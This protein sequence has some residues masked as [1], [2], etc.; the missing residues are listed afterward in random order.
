MTPEDL[1]RSK[2]ARLA[3]ADDREAMEFAA[4]QLELTRQHHDGVLTL[5]DLKAAA[6]TR[7]DVDRLLRRNSL[8]QVHRTVYVDH[9]G[10][11]TRTQRIWAAVF[12]LAPAVICGRTL[13]AP[14]SLTELDP[15]DIA[16]DWT[17]RVASPDGV[18]VHRVRHLDSVAQ[19]KAEPP[20]MRR[21]DAVL[22]LVDAAADDLE[23]VRLLTDAARDLNVGVERLREAERRRSRLRRRLFVVALLDDMARGAQSVL[24]YGYLTRVERAHGLPT[25][26]RQVLRRTPGGK[27]YRDVEYEVFGLVVELDG[28]LNHHSFDAESRDAGRDLA[29]Q[30]SGRSVTRLRWRQVFGGACEIA[31]HVA[32]LLQQRG[33]TGLPTPCSPTCPVGAR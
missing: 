7:S 5:A 20:R 2:A 13:L 14:E 11:L 9:T 1:A 33:W 29:D 19:W 21:E 22:M 15:I 4:F 30:V 3:D 10:A 6:L 16:V 17:R 31:G 32:T 8:R 23:V 24:E 26:S 25:A 18:R 28:R 27:E 12:A